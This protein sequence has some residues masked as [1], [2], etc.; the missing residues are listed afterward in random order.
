MQVCIFGGGSAPLL[1]TLTKKE[2]FVK[3]L[4]RQTTRA[5]RWSTLLAVAVISLAAVTIPEVSNAEDNNLTTEPEIAVSEAA[6]QP[7]DIATAT[8]ETP[9]EETAETEHYFTESTEAE[10]TYTAPTPARGQVFS[11]RE[12]ILSC[13][14]PVM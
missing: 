2:T 3:N 5:S 7:E 10:N 14:V 13:V 12:T 4:R 9:S 8:L 6:E 1:R 11:Q